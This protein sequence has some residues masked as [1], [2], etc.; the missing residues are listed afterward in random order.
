MLL[1]LPV[2]QAAQRFST[3]RTCSTCSE[4]ARAL[5]QASQVKLSKQN[6][7]SQAKS[8]LGRKRSRDAVGAL[9]NTVLCYLAHELSSGTYLNGAITA[10][11]VPLGFLPRISGLSYLLWD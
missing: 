5:S 10:I 1:L 7:P 8:D 11:A 2:K 3:P 4:G 6:P 9:V